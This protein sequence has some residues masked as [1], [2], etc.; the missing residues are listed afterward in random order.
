QRVESTVDGSNVN[1][2][3]QLGGQRYL[4]ERFESK[5]YQ[6][7]NNL[8][9]TKG[10]TEFTFGMDLMLNNLNSLATS[11]FNGR[12]YFTGL[13]N[14]ENLQPYRYARE[15]ATE[16]P[17]VEQSIFGGGIYAQ[18]ETDL[19][20]GKSL[21]LG[22]RGDY[23]GYQNSPTF[24]QTVFDELGLRTDVKTGGFQVQPRVQFTWDINEKQQDIL[25]IGGGVF[26]SALN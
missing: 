4:P 13:D 1:T 18:A 5:V 19:G 6:L 20:R 26:G 8:Y 7:V 24:N 22:L 9:Y 10:R 15:V 2:T 21:V 11:E 3:I 23:T 14:F 17:T 16:D 12:F 25:R